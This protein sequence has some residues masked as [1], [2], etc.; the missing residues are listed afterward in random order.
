[1]VGFLLMKSRYSMLPAKT[2]GKFTSHTS[3]SLSCLYS[4]DVE[5][6]KKKENENATS[7]IINLISLL[8]L[9]ARQLPGRA[10]I[11]LHNH[12]PAFLSRKEMTLTS[13]YIDA[14][15]YSLFIK[16]VTACTTCSLFRRAYFFLLILSKT[17]SAFPAKKAL[18]IFFL[19]Q[20]RIHLRRRQP[21]HLKSVTK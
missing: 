15:W 9:V 17:T 6:K 1:M 10:A 16:S 12:L 3:F 13:T 18:G 19:K 7:H 20:T 21:W 5:K 4:C 2:L 8:Y 11:H 14:H